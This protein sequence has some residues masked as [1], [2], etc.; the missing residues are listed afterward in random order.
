MRSRRAREEPPIEKERK[1]PWDRR[2]RKEGASRPESLS[3]ARKGEKSGVQ[4]G[5]EE[6][7]DDEQEEG[8]VGGIQPGEYGGDG[9]E[10]KRGGGGSVRSAKGEPS[11]A[12]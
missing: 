4:G 5:C 3:C 1:R 11:E 7:D 2:K 6:E 12:K 10:V 8:G 9:R